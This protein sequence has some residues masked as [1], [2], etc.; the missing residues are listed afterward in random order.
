MSETCT[1]E[2]NGVQY[3]RY[4]LPLLFCVS[5]CSGVFVCG[6]FVCV[7]FHMSL[8]LCTVH[9]FPCLL[10]LTVGVKKWTEVTLLVKLVTLE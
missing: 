7:S 6:V 10:L 4:T 8:A 5:V 3:I 2:N 1:P 9:M